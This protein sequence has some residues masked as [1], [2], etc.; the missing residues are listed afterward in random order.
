MLQQARRQRGRLSSSLTRLIGNACCADPHCEPKHLDH[1]NEPN[2][3]CCNPTSGDR[4]NTNLRSPCN[5]SSTGASPAASGLQPRISGLAQQQRSGHTYQQHNPTAVIHSPPVPLLTPRCLLPHHPDPSL[6]A[7]HHGLRC[8]SRR[9]HA[10]KQHTA[11]AAATVSDTGQRIRPT[12]PSATGEATAAASLAAPAAAARAAS[13]A[14]PGPPPAPCSPAPG[15]AVRGLATQRHVLRLGPTVQSLCVQEILGRAKM[16]TLFEVIIVRS[17]GRT[18]EPNGGLTAS[19]LGL[20]SRDLSLFA[21]DSRLSPQRATIAVRGDRILFRS[22]AIK[23]VIEREQCTLIKNKRDR[24][25]HDIIKPMTLVIDAQPHVPFELS[26]LEVLLHVTLLYFERRRTHISWMIERIMGDT[27]SGAASSGLGGGGQEGALGSGDPFGGI[28]ESTVQQFVPLEKVITS[29]L[30]DARETCDAINRFLD[31]DR[32]ALGGLLLSL[33]YTPTSALAA[34]AP[35]ST[36]PRLPRYDKAQYD[37]SR[38]DLGSGSA[39]FDYDALQQECRAEQQKRVTEPMPSSSSS[40]G[41]ASCSGVSG[42]SGGGSAAPAGGRKAF[43]VMTPAIGGADPAQR[44][45]M[46]R[47]QALE[48]ASRILD[49]YLREMES[50][51]GSLLEAEDYLESTRETYRMQLDSAR[52]HII[53]VNL[54]TSVASISLMVAALPSAFFGMNVQHGMEEFRGAFP[55]IVAVSLGLAVASYPAFMRHFTERFLRQSRHDTRS[56]WMLRTFLMQHSDDLEAITDALHSLPVVTHG[57]A[58]GSTSREHFKRHLRNRLPRHV[59]LTNSQL[60]YLYDQFERDKD[61]VLNEIEA[62]LQSSK[63][64]AGRTSGAGRGGGH[65]GMGLGQ[66]LFGQDFGSAEAEDVADVAGVVGS[67]GEP[68]GGEDSGTGVGLKRGRKGE[69]MLTK[70][71]AGTVDQLGRRHGAPHGTMGRLLSKWGRA[72]SGG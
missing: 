66:G 44:R 55:L 6:P 16:N 26:V 3:S 39:T 30:N 7:P 65:L 10:P 58:S 42:V 27:S 4:D 24:D 61:G 72:G 21:S 62:T 70:K 50:I 15:G 5:T 41:A 17:D 34:A 51:V 60:D 68:L 28:G 57:S 38:Y 25:F 35:A 36:T 54:W 29:V 45:A 67:D 46:L 19:D 11:P 59:Q 32:E 9:T 37:V 1:A 12:D 64:Y 13:S 71:D 47:N 69:G 8:F 43:G 2:N 48:D 33:P 20:H 52:N 63:N 53:L 22:E 56:L 14:A 31:D 49:T 18:L 40:D 23:A